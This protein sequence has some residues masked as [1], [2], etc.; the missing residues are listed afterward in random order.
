[1]GV[2]YRATDPASGSM[3]ALKVLL[4]ADHAGDQATRRFQKEAETARLVDHPNV[5]RVHE[6]GWHEGKP[7]FTMDL[8]DGGSLD[9]LRGTIRDP[10]WYARVM[11]GVARGLHAAHQRGL[12]HRDVK[13][14]NI[15]MAGET[16]CLTDFGLA[17]ELS[18]VGPRLTATGEVLGTPHYMAP[19]QASSRDFDPAKG[20]QY[21]VGAVLYDLLCGR[22]PHDGDSPVAVMMSLAT[23]PHTPVKVLA[24]QVPSDLASIIE[25]ALA[26]E[27]ALRYPD[28][29]AL[30]VDLERFVGGEPVRA[31][32]PTWRVQADRVF[33]GARRPLMAA[34][35][36]TAAALVAIAAGA[37]V[38]SVESERAVF[39]REL[40]AQQDLLAA[41]ADIEAALEAG[42]AGA[43]IAALRAY[44]ARHQGTHAAIDAILRDLPR[45]SAVAPKR[46]L[47]LLAE[48]YTTAPDPA[49]QARVLDG[50][51]R[52]L[53]ARWEWASLAAV[54]A[55]QARRQPLRAMSPALAQPRARVQLALGDAARA[56]ATFEAIGDGP[57]ASLARALSVSAPAPEGL[58]FHRATD[59]DGDGREDI[60][61][62]RGDHLDIHA[63]VPGLPRIAVIPL[64][65][66]HGPERIHLLPD[67]GLVHWVEGT[68]HLIQV[69]DH[70]AVQRIASRESSPALA[71]ARVDL[72]QD[73]LAEVYVGLGPYERRLL[74]Y[75]PAAPGIGFRDA[76]AP[77]TG[78]QSDVVRLLPVPSASGPQLWA[79]VGPWSA[80]DVRR[81]ASQ[82]GALTLLDRHRLGYVSQLL[83]LA[84]GRV[85]A[86]HSP[87]Y[88]SRIA[89]DP[90][91]P[92]GP[93]IGVYLLDPE[94]PSTVEVLPWV[95][96]EADLSGLHEGDLDGDGRMDLVVSAQL[97]LE[98][99]IAIHLA[100]DR[101]Y[102]DPLVVRGQ[103]VLA[104]AQLDDDPMDELLVWSGLDAEGGFAIL[105]AGDASER[106]PPPDVVPPAPPPGGLDAPDRAAWERAEDL[107]AMGL[108]GPAAAAFTRLHD[109]LPE[110][111]GPQTLA[112]A[113]RLHEAHGDRDAAAEAWTRLVGRHPDART[114]AAGQH[115]AA[116]RLHRAEAVGGPRAPAGDTHWDL[117]DGPRR[118]DAFTV[119]DPLGAQETGEGLVL[120]SVS[121]EPALAG[122]RVPWNGE[123]LSLELTIHL[124]H[125]EWGGGIVAEID[126]WGPSQAAVRSWGG[127]GLYQRNVECPGVPGASLVTSSPTVA[128]DETWSVRLDWFDG[129]LLCQIS[130][131]DGRTAVGARPSEGPPVG[132]LDLTLR[133]AHHAQG[134]HALLRGTVTRLAVTATQ[135]LPRLS[136]R[137]T[138]PSERQGLAHGLR[139]RPAQAVPELLARLGPDALVPFRDVHRALQ[140]SHPH[141][142]VT[143]RVYTVHAAPLLALDP[144][145][146]SPDNRDA[147]AEIL[148]RRGMAWLDLSEVEAAR[149]DLQAADRLLDPGDV[150]P[151]VDDPLALL[152]VDVSL[153]LAAAW[154]DQAPETA[155]R[156]ARRALRLHPVPELAADRIATFPSLRNLEGLWP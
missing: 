15:L 4:A 153:A 25:Q 93:Q 60:A 12:A 115:V 64:G 155:R 90:D 106:L 131:P 34:G 46:A 84:D 127:G 95:G 99:A 19:E 76:H 23:R 102:R 1:M 69:D 77:T 40:V 70:D 128:L 120:Q 57:G 2:V 130:G 29:A 13:P 63:L 75:D 118:A 10:H 11:A 26:R 81:F 94:D 58:G 5:V 149:A 144:S 143:Q 78:A 125:L 98:R 37:T 121:G 150:P 53:E 91:A 18:S 71:A 133:P 139:S 103:T 9:E 122:V 137:T 140:H 85:A 43:A 119:F 151:L 32:R 31:L 51:A 35:L 27:P 74:I 52:T 87:E 33:F 88:P 105:G 7:Y 42:D 96:P 68:L 79:A 21:S 148:A 28:C 22:P 17:R 109:L 145:G 55:T 67:R 132:D 86:L 108:Y 101:G 8:I 141:A 44:W 92:Y 30:A 61:V 36:L 146:L 41:D 135:A 54:T 65:R 134:T 126:G 48:A 66:A 152:R 100:T 6:L 138:P 110:A 80:Y 154:A 72:D 59:W 38:R 124:D 97:G 107:V 73:G 83:L 142:P 50:L 3:V 47:E 82:D 114:A 112:R 62:R 49:D 14:S 89:M 111:L 117:V 39:E 24:P 147:Y 136:A 56:A 123:H 20:D 16:P 156:H 113:A 104:V 129:E 45:L 116:H